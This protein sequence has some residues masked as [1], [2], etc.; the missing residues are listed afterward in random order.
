MKRFLALFSA[1]N[2]EY[3]RDK[4]SVAW[5]L[6]FPLLIV[7]G[8]SFAFS[9][10]R[11]E[12]FKVAWL[13]ST[14]GVD[15]P[16]HQKI[17]DIRYVRFLDINEK[18]EA[19]D[20]LRRH[21]VDMLIQPSEQIQYWI[22]ESA[23]KGY[24]LEKMFFGSELSAQRVIQ[25]QT[26]EGREVRYVDWLLG[27]LLSMNIMFSSLFGVGYVIVRYRKAG[28]LRRLKATPVSALE[29]L[30][31]QVASRFLLTLFMAAVVILGC[32]IFVDFQ[33]FGS[34]FDL[35]V[36]FGV[37]SLCFISLALVVAAQV[38]SEEFAGGLLNVLSWPMMLFSGVWFS[39]EGTNPWLQKLALV[40]P[41]T[42]MVSA[43]RS[44]MTEGASLAQVAH[45]LGILAG[46]TLV[47]MAVS[48]FVFKW[49]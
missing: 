13:R 3:F 37:G 21:Q 12:V 28:V 34:Y 25:K 11:Q 36:V 16:L 27:G 23:P 17:R 22:N 9:D 8:F 39:L 15:S 44:V 6:L 4:G 29:F 19:L 45:H 33:M 48:S 35:F 31:A 18:S 42:H 32:K 7:I 1:R 49:E 14:E 24:L 46:L 30:S 41:L 20:K 38:A 5:G 10:T 26:V 47:F 43:A 2:K 40:F